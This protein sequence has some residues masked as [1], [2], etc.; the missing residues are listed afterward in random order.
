MDK[1]KLDKP[2]YCTNCKSEFTIEDFGG[3]PYDTPLE[4][5]VDYCCL[6]KLKK[7]LEL[8]YKVDKMYRD[9]PESRDKMTP[10]HINNL[11]LKPNEEEIKLWTNEDKVLE[12]YL[13]TKSF[14]LEYRIKHLE[15]NIKEDDSKPVVCTRCGKGIIVF[16][17]GRLSDYE[18]KLT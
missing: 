5:I 1:E 12:K 18:P 8:L 9:Y 2:L 3:E 15:R 16:K 4:D 14:D 11:S 13:L 10:Q 7:E 6:E 17:E